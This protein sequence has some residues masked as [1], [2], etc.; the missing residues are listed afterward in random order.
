MDC[1]T[2]Y[3]ILKTVLLSVGAITFF[4]G[5]LM[6]WATTLREFVRRIVREELERK[7]G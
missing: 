5:L 6:L 1:W 4:L 2:T 7:E 3:T